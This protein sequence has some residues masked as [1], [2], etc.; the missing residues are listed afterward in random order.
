MRSACSRIA[1]SPA[2][3]TPARRARRQ[4][5]RSATSGRVDGE[6]GGEDTAT[7]NDDALMG[8]V[9]RALDSGAITETSLRFAYAWTAL[10]YVVPGAVA[11]AVGVDVSDA[12]ALDD[13][14]LMTLAVILLACEG[15][16]AAF[17]T[18][19]LD[20][21][22]ANATF[23]LDAAETARGVAFGILAAVVARGV[24]YA[25]DA[26]VSR[27]VM[28]GAPVSGA[29]SF[30]TSG[31]AMVV[32]TTVAASCAVAPFLE[33]LFFRHFLLRTIE[34]K[35]KSRVIAIVGSSAVF[36]G[37]HFSAHD[38]PSLFACGAVFAAA[39]TSSRTFGVSIVAH[40]VYNA[41]VLIE[42]SLI[43]SHSG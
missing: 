24:D 10:G 13:R 32:A 6:D 22:G 31:D 42:S 30:M 36:A 4:P 26:L 43:Y 28:N 1:A 33:E 18:R 16:K 38:A 27:D 2:A 3:K 35:T 21:V 12:S 34:A 20:R 9:F 11:S 14:A 41:S 19:T 23:R 37:A 40:G 39:A 29:A 25:C 7:K 17:T 5:R 8:E 15:A